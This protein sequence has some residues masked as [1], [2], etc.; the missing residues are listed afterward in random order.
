MF[1]DEDSFMGYFSK[2]DHKGWTKLKFYINEEYPKGYWGN[3][4]L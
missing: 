2:E 1:K 3:H 4:T